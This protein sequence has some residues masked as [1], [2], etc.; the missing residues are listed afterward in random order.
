[1]DLPHGNLLTIDT[2]H[3]DDLDACLHVLDP[4]PQDEADNE[5]VPVEDAR[6]CTQL[7]KTMDRSKGRYRPHRGDYLFRCPKDAPKTVQT[8]STPSPT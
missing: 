4:A 8:R 3:V 2:E 5:D 1:M 6:R 7:R